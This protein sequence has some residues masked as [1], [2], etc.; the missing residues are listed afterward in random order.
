MCLLSVSG[1][2]FGKGCGRKGGRAETECGVRNAD[3]GVKPEA[4]PRDRRGIRR[5]GDAGAQAY[6][7]ISNFGLPFD[8]AQGLELRAERQILD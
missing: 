5:H 7:E 2:A 1:R 4:N 3:C 6:G 8:W